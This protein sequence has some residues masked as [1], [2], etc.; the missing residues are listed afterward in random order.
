MEHAA[1][2]ASFSLGKQLIRQMMPRFDALWVRRELARVKEA[3]ALVVRFG[4]M[5]FGG[6]HDT[7]DSIEAAMKDMTLTPHELRGIADS[8][9]GVEQVRKYMKASDLDTPLIKEL[10]DSF[11]EHQQLASS[12]DRCGGSG[13]RKPGI[14]KYPE[15]HFVLQCGY[16]QRGTAVSLTQC[17]Q[18]DGYDHDDAQQPYLRACENQ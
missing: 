9:R 17:K 14:E 6:I 12:I 18:A 4:N 2:H 8:T 16:Q 3:Y 10:C 5:P 11:A 13:F 7:R 1:K 15:I